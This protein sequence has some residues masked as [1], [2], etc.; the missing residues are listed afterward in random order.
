MRKN[1]Y[2]E[3]VLPLTS[4][5]APCAVTITK[6]IYELVHGKGSEHARDIRL[7]FLSP[8]H[9]VWV[10]KRLARFLCYSYDQFQLED[11]EETD[12]PDQSEDA[13]EEPPGIPELLVEQTGTWLDKL[14][15]N[16][17]DDE[18]SRPPSREESKRLFQK[19]LTVEFVP[20][21]RPGR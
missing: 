3:E 13:P 11:P 21:K 14:Y 15:V 17:S 7:V 1:K 4:D 6:E 2:Q 12:P 10:E 18:V 5:P 19:G 8:E 9:R 20:K 16:F